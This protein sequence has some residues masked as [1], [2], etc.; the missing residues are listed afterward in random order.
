[1][2]FE[3]WKDI[4]ISKEEFS[5]KLWKLEKDIEGGNKIEWNKDKKWAIS[6]WKDINWTRI[7]AYYLT[8]NYE[9][10]N[11]AKTDIAKQLW[12]K[13][14]NH[15]W[16]FREKDWV[17]L[18][19]VPLKWEKVYLRYIADWVSEK[20]NTTKQPV[21][22]SRYKKLGSSLSEL[23]Q[24]DPFLSTLKYQWILHWLSVKWLTA[25]HAG[26]NFTV[27]KFN[28]QDWEYYLVTTKDALSKPASIK[29]LLNL[30]PNWNASLMLEWLPKNCDPSALW[31]II[32]DAL[33]SAYTKWIYL[34]S[35]YK[36]WK[37]IGIN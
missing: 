12:V 15:F 28:D 34:K 36:N 27:E 6:L 26:Y 35:N 30:D 13:N 22:I 8:E 1:M 29:G 33:V 5:W 19:V 21:W 32:K 24:A 14:P 3:N 23:K 17:Q 37:Y 18:D 11:K 2:W 16:I 20:T 31:T 4:L 7:Y 25:S 10:L 9:G